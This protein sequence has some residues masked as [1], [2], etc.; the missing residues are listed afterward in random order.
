MTGGRTTSLNKVI[1]CCVMLRAFR[2]N[3]LSQTIIE[4]RAK[5][6]KVLRSQILETFTH[7]E[8]RHYESVPQGLICLFVCYG[9]FGYVI[10]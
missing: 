9:A 3:L 1:V 7:C 5:K 4:M 2:L 8:R 6:N 10:C